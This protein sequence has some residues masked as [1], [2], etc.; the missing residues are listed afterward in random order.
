MRYL[1]TKFRYHFEDLVDLVCNCIELI[2]LTESCCNEFISESTCKKIEFRVLLF[3]VLGHFHRTV[4]GVGNLFLGVC[5]GG[6]PNFNFLAKRCY[7][8]V[9]HLLIERNACQPNRLWLH[10]RSMCA[11]QTGQLQTFVGAA[12]FGLEPTVFGQSCRVWPCS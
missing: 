8:L 7:L 9:F 10:W 3:V 6:T 2:W 12:R 11:G 5:L 4:G 1:Q